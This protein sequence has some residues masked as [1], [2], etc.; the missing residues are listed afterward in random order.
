M[1][2]SVFGV[3]QEKQGYLWEKTIPQGRETRGWTTKG[4]RASVG[5]RHMRWRDG[6]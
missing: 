1:G 6:A 2:D 5:P 4:M 3:E